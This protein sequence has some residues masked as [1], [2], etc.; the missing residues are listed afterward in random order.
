MCKNVNDDPDVASA[1]CLGAAALAFQILTM[2]GVG[3]FPAGLLMFVGGLLGNIGTSLLLCCNGRSGGPEVTVVSGAAPPSRARAGVD[4]ATRLKPAAILNFVAAGLH[5]LGSILSAVVY[6]VS[7]AAW[8]VSDNLCKQRL[9]AGTLTREG[10]ACYE[11]NAQVATQLFTW[12]VILIPTVVFAFV[13]ALLEALCA[14]KCLQGK[15]NIELPDVAQ[16]QAKMKPAAG[17]RL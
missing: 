4:I 1:K 9:A 3:V 11:E 13:A 5:V 6:G 10:L 2:V 14:R 7:I 12:L 17:S 15:A 16:D 8:G